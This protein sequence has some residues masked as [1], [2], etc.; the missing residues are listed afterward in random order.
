MNRPLPLLSSQSNEFEL[1]ESESL[2]ALCDDLGLSQKLLLAGID[3]NGHSFFD[4]LRDQS[5]LRL[6]ADN[7][8]TDDSL[9]FLNA[10]TSQPIK[11]DI[12][13]IQ[14]FKV[15]NESEAI[16]IVPFHSLDGTQR[17][18]VILSGKEVLEAQCVEAFS[19]KLELMLTQRRLE[20]TEKQ[21]K[22]A[23]AW[24]DQELEE[25]TRLQ[26]LML[27]SK[28]QSIPGSEI[29]FTYRAMRGAGGDYIDFISKC[30]DPK[31]SELH[32]LGMIVA[33]VT[34]HG[35]SAAMEV[36]MMDAIIR[37]Y[38]PEEE[39]Q[40]SAAILDYVNKHFFTRKERS[41]FITAVAY[42]Y[43]PINRKVQYANAGHPNAYIK[44]GSEIISLD[45]G[46]IPIGVMRDYE[47]QTYI[48]DVEVGDTLFVYTDVVIETK[49]PD[50]QDF[51]FERLELALKQ[52][53]NE[54][55]SLLKSIEA[56]LKEFCHCKTF[57][58]DMTMCAVQFV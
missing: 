49:N 38:R 10:I 26:Q 29:A 37:T 51:G 34:G 40:S 11:A 5:P 58:D 15:C 50:N 7:S 32:K 12:V 24:I 25:M 30:E 4:D 45:G 2:L 43:C 9:S 54:P 27:P 31:K 46:G 16:W 35:P 28:V 1:S 42:Q 20:A 3:A 53:D 14:Q 55:Q 47:W 36:A 17:W 8:L 41:S 6:L 19:L 13:H 23:N 21:L 44:R 22:K 57:Q 56:T 52:A 48:Q 33:D 18:L 39:F